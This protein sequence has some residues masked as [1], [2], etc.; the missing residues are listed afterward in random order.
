MRRN[1]LRS[2]ERKS[3]EPGKGGLESVRDTEDRLSD[4]ILKVFTEYILFAQYH[5]FTCFLSFNLSNS[6]TEVFTFK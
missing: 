5:A 4:Q 1:V 6:K 2:F 3:T